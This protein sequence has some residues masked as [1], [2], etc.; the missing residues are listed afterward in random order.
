[1]ARGCGLTNKERDQFGMKVNVYKWVIKKECWACQW[2][3]PPGIGVMY[4]AV[5]I[6]IDVDGFVEVG[7][8]SK[9]SR[10]LAQLSNCVVV[11]ELLILVID[12]TS[13][14]RHQKPGLTG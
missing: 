1:M 9:C 6:W 12:H 8:I 7:D 3:G 2:L 4:S 13:S 14:H 5:H 10:L 11:E